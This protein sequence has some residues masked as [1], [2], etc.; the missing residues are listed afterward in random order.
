MKWFCVTVIFALTVSPA[1]TAPHDQE[2]RKGVP[3]TVSTAGGRRH[4]QL[5][6]L[7]GDLRF[8]SLEIER[9][10]IPAKPGAPPLPD[11]SD[12]FVRE[13]DFVGSQ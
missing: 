4:S 5:F 10:S 3:L 1:T 7:G 6:V 11:R 9:D 13:D 2:P 8:A 12:E